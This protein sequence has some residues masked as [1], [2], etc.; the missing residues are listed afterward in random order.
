MNGGGELGIEHYDEFSIYNFTIFNQLPISQCSK[1]KTQIVF[2]RVKL[3]IMEQTLQIPIRVFSFYD[4]QYVQ[5]VGVNFKNHAII[6]NAITVSIVAGERLRKGK[7]VWLRGVEKHLFYDASL[8]TLGKF[9]KLFSRFVSVDRSHGLY[10]DAELLNQ[11]FVCDIFALSNLFAR[12]RDIATDDANVKRII[13]IGAGS[14]VQNST[15]GKALFLRL[16]L[17][18]RLELF[19]RVKNDFCVHMHT[20]YTWYIR[21]QVYPVKMLRIRVLTRISQGKIEN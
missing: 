19:V 8:D 18:R 4:E 20:V 15:Q 11:L 2:H 13:N 7:W 14:A 17:R 16:F 1:Q 3:G 6:T 12:T 5:C 21:C 10:F 9:A